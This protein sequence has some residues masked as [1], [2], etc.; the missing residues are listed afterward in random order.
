MTAPTLTTKR[1]ILREHRLE[2]FPAYAALRA[3]PEVMRHLED[4]KILS[5][6][7]AWASFLKNPGMWQFAGFG[8]WMIVEKESDS[9]IGGVG[10]SDRKR[11][12]GED[13]R[14]VPEM[15]WSLATAA[16]GKGYAT[17]AVQAALAWG[18]ERFSAA[19]VIALVNEEN[20]A[21]IR[22]AEKCGFKEF[23][24]DLSAGRPRIY[25]DRML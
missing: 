24:R 22:V 4:G 15:S 11:D 2:D 8:S 23:K 25:F 1:L 6:E 5:E 18:R 20:F 14:G 7:E 21:S 17:E 13:L 19:R 9:V 12:R 16:S 10:F 3:D